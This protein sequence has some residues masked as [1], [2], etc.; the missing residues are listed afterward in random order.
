VDAVVNFKM[1]IN[2]WRIRGGRGGVRPPHWLYI[3]LLKSFERVGD[4]PIFPS[5]LAMS[6]F[7]KDKKHFL[8]IF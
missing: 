6:V 1:L 2:Q 5:H 3:T 8:H 7:L 4:F